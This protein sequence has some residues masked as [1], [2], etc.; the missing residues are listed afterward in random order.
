MGFGPP[1][2]FSTDT[3]ALGTESCGRFFHP[4]AHR[5]LLPEPSPHAAFSSFLPGQ[6][7]RF[8]RGG[9]S[10]MGR[11]TRFGR[12]DAE[13][14][15]HRD[16][17]R[18]K[19]RSRYKA[20]KKRFSMESSSEVGQSSTYQPPPLG[21]F[22]WPRDD[23]RSSS[24]PIVPIGFGQSQSPASPVSQRQFHRQAASVGVQTPYEIQLIFE[25]NSV[26]H[27]V[28]SIMP[29]SQLMVEAGSIFGVDPS[30]MVLLLLTYHS[31]DHPSEGCDDFG[32]TPSHSWVQGDGFLGFECGSHS[33]SRWTRAQ[34][35]SRY[36]G[37][38]APDI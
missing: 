4:D 21:A 1:A 37:R 34:Q 3:V 29:I 14:V 38:S 27:R 28:W 24:I 8:D 10:E 5:N 36:S 23:N 19:E 20:Y 15:T 11:S 25:G 9:V 12:D 22:S 35:L 6:A 16:N 32:T 26:Q 31:A 7:G 13:N 17:K 18:P 2:S 30:E 33:Q